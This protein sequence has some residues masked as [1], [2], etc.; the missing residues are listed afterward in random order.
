MYRSFPWPMS[1]REPMRLV[2]GETELSKCEGGGIFANCQRALYYYCHESAEQIQND[3]AVDSGC[4][5]SKA[6]D[7]GAGWVWLRHACPD[8]VF[9]NQID[10]TRVEMGRSRVY[11]N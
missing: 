10:D 6:A 2:Y 11:R 8:G 4:Y 9:T 5:V 7:V 3:E 1:F